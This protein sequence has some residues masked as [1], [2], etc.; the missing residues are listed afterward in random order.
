[1]IAFVLAVAVLVAAMCVAVAL[2]GATT[3]APPDVVAHVLAARLLA[4]DQTVPVSLLLDTAET[5]GEPRTGGRRFWFGAKVRGAGR[6]VF[7][8]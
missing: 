8:W 1:M 6:S 5:V 3:E 2:G 4:T 7:A